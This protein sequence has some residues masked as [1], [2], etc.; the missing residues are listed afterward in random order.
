MEDPATRPELTLEQF[1][2]KMKNTARALKER[3]ARDPG[4]P[5][6][7][8]DERMRQLLARIQAK[9]DAAHGVDW[10]L[11]YLEFQRDMMI[12]GTE[13]GRWGRYLDNSFER[14]APGE[15]PRPTP[16]KSA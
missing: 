8:A 11:F 2:Q 13:F 12:L 9:I 4:G 5:G 6:S 16:Q 7:E 15:Q 14:Q 10:E 1:E 3:A